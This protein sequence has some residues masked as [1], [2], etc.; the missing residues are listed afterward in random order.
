MTLTE[1]KMSYQHNLSSLLSMY[2]Y[3][4]SNTRL[5]INHELITDIKSLHYHKF[6]S[7]INQFIP[8][9]SFICIKDCKYI[10][11]SSTSDTKQSTNY[12]DYPICI[13]KDIS[14]THI[15]AIEPALFIDNLVC[16][17]NNIVFVP[18]I[19]EYV[20]NDIR[21]HQ[22][23]LVF[24]IN[25]HKVFL[26][27]PNSKSLFNDNS[28]MILLQEYIHNLNNILNDYGIPSYT[29]SLYEFD[30]MNIDLNFWFTNSLT[31][32]CVVASMVFIILYYNSQDA[33]QIELLL[34]QT[35]KKEYKNVYIGM[36][37]K[38]QEYMDLFI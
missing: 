25:K 13:V 16:L 15:T 4:V 6:I 38:L 11:L 24:D 21:L 7:I 37:N 18:V 14:G 34:Q 5:K 36:Y 20:T 19:G 17:N 28:T 27:D 35:N 23:T 32:N 30:N 1:T 10:T 33:S 8:D 29:F 31:G 9:I 2:I 3:D 26:H 12:K 22:M